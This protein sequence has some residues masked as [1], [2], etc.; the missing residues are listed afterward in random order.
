MLFQGVSKEFK[1]SLKEVSKVVQERF[2][3]YP[4]QFKEC[5]NEGSNLFLGIF[6]DVSRK[7]QGCFKI[8]SGAYQGQKHRDLSLSQL[9]HSLLFEQFLQAMFLFYSIQSKILFSP[10][11]NVETL[12]QLFLLMLAVPLALWSASCCCVVF[13]SCCI[14]IDDWGHFRVGQVGKGQNKRTLLLL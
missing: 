8:V 14:K 6:K 3:G 1:K 5:F 4:K 13:I 2:W 11:H 9:S 10:R 12:E 7:V